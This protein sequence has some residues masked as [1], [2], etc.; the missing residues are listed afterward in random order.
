MVVTTASLEP[1]TYRRLQHLAIDEGTTVREL[2]R[3][4]VAEY[5]KGQARRKQHG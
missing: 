2:I 4:A 5:L 3:R 1:G